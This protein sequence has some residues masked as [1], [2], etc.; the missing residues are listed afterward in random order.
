MPWLDRPSLEFMLESDPSEGIRSG[1][2]QDLLDVFFEV[3]ERRNSGGSILL[4]GYCGIISN[5]DEADELDR[6]FLEISGKIEERMIAIEELAELSAAGRVSEMFGS[7]T[8]AVI[9]PVG[10]LKWQDCTMTFNAGK[11]GPVSQRMYDTITGIQYGRLQ[12][13]HGWVV[14]L[15]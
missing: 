10:T 13:P 15:V 1:E 12:D 5:F 3:E 11:I 7:G 9:S 4:F 2:I 8:A 6:S 14:T